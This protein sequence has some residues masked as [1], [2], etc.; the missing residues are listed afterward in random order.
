MALTFV[1]QINR[2]GF[3]SGNSYWLSS[4]AN[5]GDNDWKIQKNIF[6]SST[7]KYGFT[8]IRAY[9]KNT[10]FPDWTTT[11]PSNSGASVQYITATNPPAN[12]QI[13]GRQVFGV[14]VIKNADT[15]KYMNQQPKRVQYFEQFSNRKVAYQGRA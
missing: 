5:V 12:F 1:G 2:S 13:K 6:G 15:V 14:P 8:T 11:N 4:R 10:L 3:P 9:F 7:E